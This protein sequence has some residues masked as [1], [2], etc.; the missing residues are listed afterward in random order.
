VA[1]ALAAALLSAGC[2]MGARGTLVL[3]DDAGA[4]RRVAAAAGDAQVI[5]LGEQHDNPVHHRHQRAVLEALLADGVRPAIGFEMLSA[6]SQPA[7]DAAIADRPGP[8]QLGE[9]LRWREAGWPDFSMYWPL[10]E[11]ALRERLPV[12][13][14]DLD[15][16]LT[17]AIAREGLAAAGPDADRLRSLLPP[18]GARDADVHRVIF[19]AHCGLVPDERVRRL[20]EAWHA[21]N[22]GMARRIA[23]ALDDRRRV[24]VIAGRGHQAPGGLPAQLEALRPGTRQIVVDLVEVPAGEDPRALAVRSTADAVWATPA[25]TRPDPCAPLRNPT[26]GPA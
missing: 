8:E 14:L 26:R 7:V 13:A 6:S 16:H 21:R 3:P 15:R 12:I 4:A 19:D 24:V 5:Y 11:L 18:D 9:R 17:R 10:F 25:V 23:E 20:V 2:A 22:V 1:S